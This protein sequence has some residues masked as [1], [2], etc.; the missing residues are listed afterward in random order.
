MGLF[1]KI[2]LQY[3]LRQ[4][5]KI[6]AEMEA[7]QQILEEK[8]KLVNSITAEYTKATKNYLD[9][10]K[11][12][13]NTD[14]PVRDPIGYSKIVSPILEEARSGNVPEEFTPDYYTDKTEK[15]R[16]ACE[17]LTRIYEKIQNNEL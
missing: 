13:N 3:Q 7:R 15:H 17:K 4:S 5:E 2:A 8:E 9:I 10:L 14:Y 1:K 6:I 11:K 16:I 12:I